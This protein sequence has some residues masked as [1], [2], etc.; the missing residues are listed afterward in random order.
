[1]DEATAEQLSR[2]LDDD[3]SDAEVR[4]LETRLR[5]DSA[6]AAELDALRALTRSVAAVAEDMEPPAALDDLVAPLRT[7]T[8]HGRRRIHPVVRV[9]GIAAGLALAATV[10]LE[11]VRRGPDETSVLTDAPPE[12]AAAPSGEETGVFQL[13]PLPT[14]AVPEDEQPV[15]AAD[16]L[17][18]SPPTEP[19]LDEPEPLVVRGPL[20]ADEK[21][22]VDEG[23]A[24]TER[25]ARSRPSAP[26]MEEKMK[27]ESTAGKEAPAAATLEVARQVE[28][29]AAAEPAVEFLLVGTN[30][31]VV[32]TVSLPAPAPAAST[33]VVKDGVI[34][35]LAADDPDTAGGAPSSDWLGRPVGDVPDGRY[36]IVLS[37]HGPPDAAR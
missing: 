15:G 10:V 7:G 2:Y 13:S 32:A 19:E 23:R 14:S 36:R 30:G 26:P 5:T 31:A 9:A 29:D 12:T 4:E 8:P 6:L 37:A 18:A 20:S 27:R 3:L 28:N 35:E 11:V 34:V 25:P 33:V 24:Q 22:A 17:L 1:M 16:R 21:K